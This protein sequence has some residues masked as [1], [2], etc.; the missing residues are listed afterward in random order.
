MSVTPVT[1]GNV[2]FGGGMN[3]GEWSEQ[4]LAVVPMLAV[5][6]PALFLRSRWVQLG[7]PL[8]LMAIWVF[9]FADLQAAL[10]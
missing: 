2:V 1:V 3:V 6:L 8:A 4:N 5:A 10:K 7:A 9:Y